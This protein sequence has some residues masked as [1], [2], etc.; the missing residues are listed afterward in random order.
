M[1]GKSPRPLLHG[2]MDRAAD[3]LVPFQVTLE[4]THRCNL[5]CKHCYIDVPVRQGLSLGALV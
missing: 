3:H 2:V 4:L 5:A 1:N